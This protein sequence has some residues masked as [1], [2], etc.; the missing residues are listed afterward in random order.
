MPVI[1]RFGVVYPT[2]KFVVTK[3]TMSGDRGGRI[4]LERLAGLDRTA[5]T[6]S[7]FAI[8]S[9]PGPHT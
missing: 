4:G 5:L 7:R 6:S 8:P 2:K 9:L 3:A 1:V